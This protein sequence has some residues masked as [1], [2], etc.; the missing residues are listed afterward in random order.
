MSIQQVTALTV[1]IL[2]YT[3]NLEKCLNLSQVFSFSFT[4]FTF[5]LAPQSNRVLKH[6]A[7]FKHIQYFLCDLCTQYFQIQH[8]TNT[9][10]WTYVWKC[11]SCSSSSPAWFQKKYF[12]LAKTFNHMLELHSKQ[13]ERKCLTQNTRAC[14]QLFKIIMKKINNFTTFFILSIIFI[15]L[16]NFSCIFFLLQIL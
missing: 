5:S 2:Q 15:L 7:S 6:G 8:H 13:W 9:W 11:D 10:T 12:Y 3:S 16:I 1:S 4:A 14:A